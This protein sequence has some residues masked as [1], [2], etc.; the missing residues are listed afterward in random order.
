[1][2]ISHY[3]TK[4]LRKLTLKE[5]EFILAQAFTVSRFHCLRRK[6]NMQTAE[7]TGTE[8]VT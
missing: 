7:H 3:K 5:E 6:Q 2:P 8:L 1:M 4:H